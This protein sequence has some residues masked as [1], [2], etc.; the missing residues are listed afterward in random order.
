[1]GSCNGFWR[2][3][4]EPITEE[5]AEIGTTSTGTRRQEP[6]K[7]DPTELPA[8]VVAIQNAPEAPE[9][10]SPSAIATLLGQQNLFKD[11]SPGFAQ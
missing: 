8:P 4:E 6:P 1:M 9:P 7:T 10:T 5:P 3:E 2:W 11:V